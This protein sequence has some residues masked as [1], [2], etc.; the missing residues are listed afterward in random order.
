MIA[1][2]LAALLALTLGQGNA[3]LQFPPGRVLAATAGFD[4]SLLSLVQG[5]QGLELRAARSPDRSSGRPD[6]ETRVLPVPLEELLPGATLVE[7]CL[8]PW[9][10]AG[11]DGVALALS[12]MLDDLVTYRYLLPPREA[13]EPD[14]E[15]RSWILSDPILEVD[16]AEAEL[17]RILDLETY[18]SGDSLQISLR[19]G[20]HG[21]RAGKRVP[22]DL[23][24]VETCPG[25]AAPLMPGKNRLVDLATG[26]TL[27]LGARL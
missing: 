17:F 19:R 2:T 22:R 18:P 16:G 14:A 8:A 7:V 10:Q 4:G 3:D 6:G 5:E 9:P 27:E 12:T 20:F 25:P 24:F 13:A 1:R 15:P 11:P 21:V 26:E 23:V